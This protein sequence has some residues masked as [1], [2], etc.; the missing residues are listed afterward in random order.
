[1]RLDI[2]CLHAQF[3]GHTCLR[4]SDATRST[5]TFWKDI[6]DT[7]GAELVGLP[8]LQNKSSLRF[9][10]RDPSM[11]FRVRLFDGLLGMRYIQ[12][13]EMEPLWS[14]IR[15]VISFL[16]LFKACVFGDEQLRLAG[17]GPTQ[18]ERQCVLDVWVL[19]LRKGVL[20][21]DSFLKWIVI[22]QHFTLCCCLFGDCSTLN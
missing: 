1:M 22:C 12:M 13:K 7:V 5:E 14:D 11:L 16:F 2:Q 15:V 20:N 19:S 21:R 17:V 18:Q 3:L 9:M 4:A 6:Q 8:S 10:H